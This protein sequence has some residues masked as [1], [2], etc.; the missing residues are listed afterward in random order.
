MRFEQG[1]IRPPSEAGSL[2][3]RFTRNCPWNRCTFCPIYKGQPFSRRSLAEITGDIDAAASILDHLSS[4]SS[5]MGYGGRLTR[6]VAGAAL[7][8]PSLSDQARHVALWALAGKGTVFIQDAN[9][10]VLE[11][12][13]LV[14]ALHHL[15]ER[16]PGVQRITSYARSSTLSRKTLDEL[17]SIRE[18]GLD[19][20]HIGLESGSDAVLAF[21]RKGATA[22]QHI[23]AGRRVIEAGMTLSEYVMPGLGGKK[24]W[25][26]HAIE[27]ARVLNEVD[28]HFIRLRSLRI[29]PHVPLRADVEAGRF[30]PLTDDETV[31]EIRL[32]VENLHPTRSVLTSD[33]IMN[34]LPELEGR[35]PRD[36]AG[37][38]AVIDRYLSMSEI[39][40][41]LY[42]LGRR[43]GMLQ[44]LDDLDDP[45]LRSRLERAR[46]ELVA[47]AGGD[48]EKVIIE[49]GDRYI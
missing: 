6:E 7:S 21:V 48:I 12:D 29:P 41:L 37:M 35:F 11:T 8:D 45:H 13:V 32:L 31:E 23:E 34:L 10:L 16:I 2:L 19:R 33:H 18:A 3:L 39:D 27:T 49:L 14:K 38:L 28:P 47:E 24:W 46:R 30:V 42:R 20:I 4:L 25:R 17:K 26:E 15:R 44:S 22:A 5:R 9:S 40:R 36:K 1:P 43:G